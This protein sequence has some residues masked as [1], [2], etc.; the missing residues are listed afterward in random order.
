MG[1]VGKVSR[2]CK[3]SGCVCGGVHMER[4][5]RVGEG[6]ACDVGVNTMTNRVFPEIC[7]EPFGHQD[8]GFIG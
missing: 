6:V 4:K 5:L 8:A 7:N 1:G 2:R 3:K